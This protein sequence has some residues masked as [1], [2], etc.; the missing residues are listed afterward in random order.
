[1]R[2]AMASIGQVKVNGPMMSN[3]YISTTWDDNNGYVYV[4]NTTGVI[5]DERF[6]STETA[7]AI[8]NEENPSLVYALATPTETPLTDSE[9]AAYR[10]LLSH[11]PTTT[12]LNDSGAYM[13]VKYAADTKTYIGNKIAELMQ[14]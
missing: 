6:T 3:R 1:M 13:A 8:L 7:A 12:L 10:A 4:A 2:F 9:I 14:S 5:T 11:K